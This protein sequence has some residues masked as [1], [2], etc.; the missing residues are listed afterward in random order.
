MDAQQS[1]LPG[2]A[3][4][5]QM[6]DR[7]DEDA[8]LGADKTHGAAGAHGKAASCG[9]LGASRQRAAAGGR[10]VSRDVVL[11]GSVLHRHGA[12]RVV[13]PKEEAR[14]DAGPSVVD[15]WKKPAEARPRSLLV[16]HRYGLGQRKD[17]SGQQAQLRGARGERRRRRGGANVLHALVEIQPVVG[18]R[19]PPQLKVATRH[20]SD[21]RRRAGARARLQLSGKPATDRM[22]RGARVPAILTRCL[23]R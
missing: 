5:E 3:D 12:A 22:R 6:L 2:R 21:R 15:F 7:R 19:V 13:A 1:D 16:P 10:G 18:R 17:A 9:G 14:V 23:A 20:L 4:D 8:R 11:F